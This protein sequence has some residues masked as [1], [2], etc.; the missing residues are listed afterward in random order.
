MKVFISS[1]YED[2][3]SHRNMVETSLMISGIPYNAMEHFGST[4]RPTIRTC[5]DSVAASDVFL[6]II[7][8]RYGGC[9]PGGLIPTPKESTD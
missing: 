6:G 3:A 2:L 1:T 7:G 9:L 8:V 4:P 5:L